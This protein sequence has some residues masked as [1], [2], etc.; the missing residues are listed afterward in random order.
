MKDVLWTWIE[1]SGPQLD[2]K[3]SWGGGTRTG[4]DMSF[5]NALVPRLQPLTKILNVEP[6][7]EFE[8]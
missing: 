3:S 5:P 8:H 2:L 4:W 6:L 1:L 7:T